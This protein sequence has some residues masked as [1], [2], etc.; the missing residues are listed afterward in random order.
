M[1]CEVSDPGAGLAGPVPARRIRPAP[2]EPGGWGLWL[3]RELTDT[4]E[5]DTGARHHGAG[6]QPYDCRKVPPFP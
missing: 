5:I 6:V 1:V 2:D 4:L 3:A